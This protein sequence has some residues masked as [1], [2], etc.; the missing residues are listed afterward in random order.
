[1]CIYVK[2][3][4]KNIDSGDFPGGPMIKTPCFHCSELGFYPRRGTMPHS[5][6]KKKKNTDDGKWLS[7][8]NNGKLT[9]MANW[10]KVKLLFTFLDQYFFTPRNMYH[11][12]Y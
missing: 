12:Y 10:V 9:V 6:K 4:F 5:K 3:S 2:K 11:F 1:M 7:Q 8:G